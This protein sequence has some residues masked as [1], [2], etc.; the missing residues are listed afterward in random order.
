MRPFA[1]VR[2]RYTMRL[3]GTA[4]HV[5][6]GESETACGKYVPSWWS[7]YVVRPPASAVCRKCGA[8]P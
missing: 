1:A 6:K 2:T 3:F 4:A 5:L 7:R 8:G